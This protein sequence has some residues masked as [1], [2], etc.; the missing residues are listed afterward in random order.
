MYLNEHYDDTYKT[1]KNIKKQLICLFLTN[2]K[3]NTETSHRSTVEIETQGVHKTIAYMSLWA[4]ILTSMTYG[5]NENFV[6]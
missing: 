2:L 5:Q 4:S 1:I 3:D 6:L